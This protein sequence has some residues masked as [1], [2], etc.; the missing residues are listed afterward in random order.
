MLTGFPGHENSLSMVEKK[1]FPLNGNIKATGNNKDGER[2]GDWTIGKEDGRTGVQDFDEST[3]T[4]RYNREF[5]I[6]HPGWIPLNLSLFLSS[7]HGLSRK[8]K[9]KEIPGLHYYRDLAVPSLSGFL[10]SEENEWE[11]APGGRMVLQYGQQYDYSKRRL[12]DMRPDF[13]E[14]ISA[15]FQLIPERFQCKWQQ[16]IINR[17]LPGESISSHTDHSCFGPV[18]ACFSFGSTAILQFSNPVKTVDLIVEPL[19]LYVMAGPSRESFKHCMKPTV[20][21]RWSVTLRTING[22]D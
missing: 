6:G 15:L 2:V 8:M 11:E 9:F 10:E 5:S 4:G 18:I 3:K 16:A 20:S 12:G 21:T 1:V 19:S 7:I 14:E 13:P 22:F 17:Y